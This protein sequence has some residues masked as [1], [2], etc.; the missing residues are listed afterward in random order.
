ML[1][2]IISLLANFFINK[3]SHNSLWLCNLEYSTPLGLGSNRTILTRGIYYG[4]YYLTLFRVIITK[5][6]MERDG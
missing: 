6:N 5:H 2:G 4:Y 3:N 1:I